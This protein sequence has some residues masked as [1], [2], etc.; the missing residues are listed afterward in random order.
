MKK[1][2]M[3]RPLNMI[4][5]A[6][7]EFDMAIDPE[8]SFAEVLFQAEDAILNGVEGHDLIDTCDMSNYHQHLVYDD[9]M[10]YIYEADGEFIGSEARDCE[11][12]RQDGKGGWTKI[13]WFDADCKNDYVVADYVVNTKGEKVMLLT[14]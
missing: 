6:T 1:N 4:M 9:G 12:Y 3:D 2:N 13:D 8:E 14:K 11:W 5:R 10:G 7:R